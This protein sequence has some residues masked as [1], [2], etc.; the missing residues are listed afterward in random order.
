MVPARRLTTLMRGAF[1]RNV[2]TLASGATLAMAIPLLF[3]P[4]LTRVYSPHEFALLTLFV[5]W[6]S[7]LAVAAG[8]RYELAVVLPAE[9]RDAAHLLAL[10]LGICTLLSLLALMP[11]L[12]ARDAIAA[13]LGAPE[14]APWL[15]FLPVSLWCAG[16]AQ[17]WVNRNNRLRRYDANAQGRIAQAL[18]VTAVQ[19][20]GGFGG[21]GVAALIIGQTAGQAAALMGEWRRDLAARFAC[22]SGLS[23]QQM[24]TLA[25]QYREFP[26]VNTPHAFVVALQESL[27]L[28]LIARFAGTS[29]VGHYGLVLRVLKLPAAIVGQAVSQVIYRDLAE[30]RTA[31]KPL[32][33]ILKKTVLLLGALAIL[34][35]GLLMVLG[36]PL[37]ALVFGP[38][39]AMAGH[40]AA[41]LAPSFYL[42]F[43]CAPAFMVPMVLKRQHTSFAIVLGWLSVN[44]LVFAGVIIQT[45]HIAWAFAAM[46][47]VMSLYLLSYTVWVM[48]LCRREDRE[49]GREGTS[50]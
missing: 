17:I 11:A 38:D 2:L 49:L 31:G 48:R 30:A 8:G 10:S 6:L 36:E 13:W 18:T 41:L 42:S 26:T 24:K 45:R 46:S 40:L 1:L 9:E 47:L 34:P 43:V 25:W 21:L 29:I 7:N 15:L 32:L 33:P 23:S 3:S 39:W 35:F 5:S 37:F 28:W 4:L 27:L 22:F 19:L 16:A 14:L 20:A 12:V 50:C 44:L